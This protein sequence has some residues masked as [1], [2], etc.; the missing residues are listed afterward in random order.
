MPEPDAY[1]ALHTDRPEPGKPT[2]VDY[3]GYAR[4]GVALAD[5]RLPGLLPPEKFTRVP[6]PSGGPESPTSSVSIDP[7]LSPGRAVAELADGT[8]IAFSIVDR[9]DIPSQAV[10]LRVSQADWDRLFC[11]RSTDESMR[12]RGLP[13]KAD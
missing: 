13:V 10:R 11:E 9:S 12:V 3:S 6:W 1:A 8:L 7:S 4:V 2:E 5:L